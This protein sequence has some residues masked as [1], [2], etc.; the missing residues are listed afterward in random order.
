MREADW[1]AAAADRLL[2]FALE[3]LPHGTPVE[4]GFMRAMAVRSCFARLP[5]PRAAMAS[6]EGNDVPHV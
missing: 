3:A 2:L 1:F 6:S 5:L 4:A